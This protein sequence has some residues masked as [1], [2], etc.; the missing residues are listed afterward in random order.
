M[1]TRL[2]DFAQTPGGASLLPG[3]ISMT[4]PNACMIET[5]YLT[6]KKG[7]MTIVDFYRVKGGEP[8][9]IRAVHYD[10]APFIVFP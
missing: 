7:G 3:Q 4:L 2:L 1:P 6:D 9:P 8:R 5:A 10:R